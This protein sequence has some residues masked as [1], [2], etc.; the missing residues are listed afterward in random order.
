MRSRQKGTHTYQP[1]DLI[2]SM[3]T[4]V[5]PVPERIELLGFAD[6]P[7]TE[8]DA[9]GYTAG[10]CVVLRRCPIGVYLPGLCARMMSGGRATRQKA[11][12]NVKVAYQRK[13]VILLLCVAW[14]SACWDESVL[15]ESVPN[16]KACSCFRVEQANVLDGQLRKPMGSDDESD[17][18]AERRV[19]QSFSLRDHAQGQHGAPSANLVVSI[20]AGRV[21]RLYRENVRAARLS[22][23]V[24]I[25]AQHLG[26]FVVYGGVDA[27]A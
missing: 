17:G 19:H 7:I 13:E 16:F 15:G 25:L 4:V 18:H 8:Q 3:Q 21:A 23:A 9:L 24:S 26:R 10:P 14:E 6:L 2:V 22:P 20:D 1:G 5:E 12:V 27:Y 11:H